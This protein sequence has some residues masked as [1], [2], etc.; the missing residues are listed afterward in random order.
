MVRQSIWLGIGAFILA[1]LVSVAPFDGRFALSDISLGGSPAAAEKGGG[2]GGHRPSFKRPHGG[3][4][5]SIFDTLEELD[6]DV[7]DGGGPDDEDDDGG[8][9]DDTGPDDDD[10]GPE[11]D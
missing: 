2:P 4:G 9:D 11:D 1:M 7:D 8:P 5:P 3:G 10:G 6:L